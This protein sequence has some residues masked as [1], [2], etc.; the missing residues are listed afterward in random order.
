MALA[1]ETAA[2]RRSG[3]YP[4]LAVLVAMALNV[5]Y[6]L[7]VHIRKSCVVRGNS[8]SRRLVSAEGGLVGSSSWLL[9]VLLLLGD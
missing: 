1:R 4:D 2:A 3:R 6:I 8:L 7:S 5:L 9:S